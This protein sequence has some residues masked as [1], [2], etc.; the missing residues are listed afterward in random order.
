ML[1]ADAL[2]YSAVCMNKQPT[3]THPTE[4]K[5]KKK[6][7]NECP[8]YAY[9]NMYLERKRRTEQIIKWNEEFV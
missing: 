3:H 8:E 6:V 5:R 9:I 4:E 2:L 7:K 1:I